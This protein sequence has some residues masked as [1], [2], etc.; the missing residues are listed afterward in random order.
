MGQWWCRQEMYFAPSAYK[1]RLLCIQCASIYHF[2][3]L[4][5][6]GRVSFQPKPLWLNPQVASI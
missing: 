2:V 5:I 3:Y 4:Q 6:Q 1:K